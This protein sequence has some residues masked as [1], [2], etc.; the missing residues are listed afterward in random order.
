M[1]VE[2]A[3]KQTREAQESTMTGLENT[4]RTRE[5]IAGTA[6][7]LSKFLGAIA[8]VTSGNKPDTGVSLKAGEATFKEVKDNLTAAGS[9]CKGAVEKFRSVVGDS[10]NEL[11][12]TTYTMGD[13]TAKELTGKAEVGT[14]FPRAITTIEDDMKLVSTQEEELRKLGGEVLA[15]LDLIDRGLQAAIVAQDTAIEAMGDVAKAF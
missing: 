10:N 8:G 2:N 4:K 7:S 6:E 13:V 14:N 9:S 15:S 3:K 12:Q 11:A 5:N 1:T